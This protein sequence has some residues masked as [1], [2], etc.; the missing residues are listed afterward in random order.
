M[1][2][3]NSDGGIVPAMD[4]VVLEVSN[5]RQTFACFDRQ[6]YPLFFVEFVEENGKRMSLPPKTQFEE[7]KEV[8]KWTVGS[9]S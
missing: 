8:D 6:A 3:L 5:L 2:S 1:H 9:F 4:I 7:D